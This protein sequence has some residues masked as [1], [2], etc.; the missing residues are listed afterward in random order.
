MNSYDIHPVVA[1][2]LLSKTIRP[3][4]D[5]YGNQIYLVLHFPTVN[6]S[7]GG[8]TSQEIDF[9]ISKNFLLTVHYETVDPLLEFSKMFEVNS[10]LEKSNMGNHAGFLFFYIVRELYKNLSAELDTLGKTLSDIEENIFE[11]KEREMVKTISSIN[12]KLINFKQAIRFHKDVLVSFEVAAK[13]FF[14]EEFAFYA[15]AISGEAYEIA[16]ILEGHKET[17]TDLWSTNDSIVSTKINEI[18]KIIAIIS[19][20]TFPLSLIAAI[21][22]M[23]TSYLPIVGMPHDFAIVMGIMLTFMLF[24][25]AYFKKKRWI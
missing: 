22:G 16:N 25:F 9:V 15:R 1:E 4:V 12:R 6:H 8:K 19:F 11:G 13:Q 21:F 23:N 2:E 5:Y 3:K 7:H 14:G 24:I 17:L 10:I 18:M 20:V